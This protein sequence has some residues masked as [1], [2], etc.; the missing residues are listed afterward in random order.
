MLKPYKSCKEMELVRR[1]QAGEA[2]AFEA[3]KTRYERRIYSLA[4][5]MLRQQPDAERVTQRTFLRALESLPR[6]HDETS[7]AAW[8]LRIASRT[9]LQEARKQKACTT[10]CLKEGNE[11][12][13]DHVAGLRLSPERPTVGKNMSRLLEQA[14]DRLDERSRL[15][16]LLRDVE[17]L[18]ATETANAL[19]LS[20]ARISLRLLHARLQLRE[21]L[22]GVLSDSARI[23]HNFV[24]ISGQ[25]SA[26]FPLKKKPRLWRSTMSS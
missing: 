17:D 21:L 16:F 7:F 26:P 13:D 23:N 3:L 6:F 20:E 18:S 14:L 11:P 8:L 9:V 1:A 2:A 10:P 12:N 22:A 15:V 5:R 19:G 25:P 24:G 4:L